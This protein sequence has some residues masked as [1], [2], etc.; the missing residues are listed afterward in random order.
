MKGQNSPASLGLLLAAGLALGA[1]NGKE[2]ESAT[3]STPAGVAVGA[4]NIA[5]VTQGDLA[6]G[7]A[8][9]GALGP[10]REATVRAQ[11]S[12][13]V[14]K[15]NVDQGTRVAAGASLAQ[16]DDRTLRDAFLSARS[17]FT[18]AQNAAERAKRDLERSERLSQAG[19]IAERDLEQA[20]LSNAAAV[21]QLADAQA[22]LTMAQKQLDD[23][24]I[25]APFAGVVSMRSVSEGDV[26]QPG[27]ALFSVVD[28]AS[29]RFEA[30]VPAAQLSQVK[31]G[32][33]VSFT[34]SGYPDK[35]F[36]GRVAR[37]SPTVDQSTGQVRIVVSVPN[38][39][40]N[41]VAGLFA[42][43]R[44]A[45]ERRSGLTTPYS[46]VDL[47]GLK[48]TVLRL[49]SGVAERVEVALGVRDEDLE[50]Y[51]ILSGVALG[52]TLLIGAAQGIT[53][54]TTVRVS[55]P[56]DQPPAK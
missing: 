24:Q 45:S 20:R 17:G 16:I 38:A 2:A 55:V 30:S 51:E 11:V 26:V 56:S 47:R 21:S 53:P 10:E 9:S 18:T 48:P 37:I 25:R 32:A 31:S 40:N 50:R 41:L 12:G 44:I 29:M 8:I 7:P 52:D 43:G 6:S 3:P 28:P 22:R 46:A 27:T 14:M 54:G 36:S 33:P 34:V 19:A 23:T 35:R 5:I 15:V 13:A 1:C 49:R 39:S 42:N 4:E